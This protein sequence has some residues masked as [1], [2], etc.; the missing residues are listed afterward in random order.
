MNDTPSP[1]DFVHALAPA[2]RHL[3]K[4]LRG[5]EP[6]RDFGPVFVVLLA[7]GIVDSVKDFDPCA[8]NCSHCSPRQANGIHGIRTRIETRTQF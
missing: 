4:A 5:T 8:T 7:L 1:R 3:I 6:R 2:I